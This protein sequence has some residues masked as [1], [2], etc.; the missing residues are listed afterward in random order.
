MDIGMQTEPGMHGFPG[1]RGMFPLIP[2][3]VFVVLITGITLF[4][5]F[6]VRRK[7]ANK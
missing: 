4:W 2:V 6:K 3:A 7:G 1:E 5:W